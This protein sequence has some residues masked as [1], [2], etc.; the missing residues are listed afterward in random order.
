MEV[1]CLTGGLSNI[2]AFQGTRLSVVF[3]LAE[4]YNAAAKDMMAT[5]SRSG[6][7]FPSPHRVRCLLQVVV[8]PKKHGDLGGGFV[9]VSVA[10]T[11]TQGSAL[12][13][14][15]TMCCWLSLANQD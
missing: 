14:R 2:T 4:G 15:N 13:T 7:V 1:V 11:K 10:M 6:F 3:F 9:P 8:S 12:V 5:L